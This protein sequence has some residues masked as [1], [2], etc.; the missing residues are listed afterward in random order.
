MT[1]VTEA[2]PVESTDE[3]AVPRLIE[4]VSLC[5]QYEGGGYQEPRYLVSRGDGQMILVSEMLYRV[6]ESIDGERT[7]AEIAADVRRNTGAD[8]SA[9]GVEYL[10]NEKLH[11][12]AIA[13]LS[14][15]VQDPPR[16]KPLLSLAM[17]GVLMPAKLVRRIAAVLAPLHSPVAVVLALCSEADAFV[18]A[19]M[20]GL[21][22]LPKLVFLVVGP[23]VDVKLIALQAGAFGR[24][25]AARFAP[26]T[27]LVAIASSLLVGGL[28]LG[29]A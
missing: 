20:S 18:A 4:G 12:M 29:G 13:T 8:V 7:L 9:P 2:A 21:P 5:G 17:H 24:A 6:A 16:S 27:F 3:H 1:E 25:F 19:A 28:L 14:E 11:P 10:V 22:L 26:A 23:A 15:P